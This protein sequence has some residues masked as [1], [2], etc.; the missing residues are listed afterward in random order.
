M[1][2]TANLEFKLLLA[3]IISK[4]YFF[5]IL[6]INKN[7]FGFNVIHPT[8]E[9]KLIIK[10]YVTNIFFLDKNNSSLF[11]KRMILDALFLKGLTK[12]NTSCFISFLL[13][14]NLINRLV[15]LTNNLTYCVNMIF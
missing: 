14:Y 6:L 11:G 13:T 4:I 15:D 9:I 2:L 7:I 5:L 10:E 3:Y 1:P 8:Y 12:N